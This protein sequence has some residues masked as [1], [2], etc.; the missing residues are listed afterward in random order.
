[1]S[2]SQATPSPNTEKRSPEEVMAELRRQ[3][4]QIRA[5]NPDMTE[6]DWDA[7]ADRLGAEVKSALGERVRASR[8][9][10]D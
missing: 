5:N 10:A 7:L 6:A 8:G 9:E 2:Q 3:R 1:M 4:A